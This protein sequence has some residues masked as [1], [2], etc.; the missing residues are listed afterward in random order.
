MNESN[1][2]A[3][4]KTTQRLWL[5]SSLAFRSHGLGDDDGKQQTKLLRARFQ[6]LES[7]SWHSALKQ[8]VFDKRQIESERAQSAV[9]GSMPMEL[10]TESRHEQFTQQAMK[11]KLAAAR[12]ILEGKQ[13]APPNCE[14][15]RHVADLVAASAPESEELDFA[16]ALQSAKAEASKACGP[17][18]SDV[19]R[20]MFKASVNAEP[21][22]SSMRNCFVQTLGGVQNGVHALQKWLALWAK[23][24]IAPYAQ[25]LWGRVMLIPIQD[26]LRPRP[27][28]L[29]AEASIPLP[30]V[31][32]TP[33]IRLIGLAESLLKI[34]EGALLDPLMADIRRHL[35]PNQLGVGT[36]DGVVLVIS[37]LRCWA[38]AICESEGTADDIEDPSAI[39]PIDLRNAYGMFLRSHALQAAIGFNSQVASLAAAEWAQKPEYYIEVQGKWQCQQTHRGFWQGRR[40]AML[41]FCLSLARSLADSELDL[42]A[43][44]VAYVSIQDDTYLIGSL[45]TFSN[46]RGQ[47]VQA[48]ARGGHELQPAKSKAWAPAWDGKPSAVLPDWAQQLFGIVERSE[49]GVFALGAASQGSYETLLGPWSMV[50]AKAR[51][52][53]NKAQEAASELRT[54]IREA[55][56]PHALHLAWDVVSQSN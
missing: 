35:E 50:A 23:D 26:G 42:R 52:R 49:G 40:L 32:A 5:L 54:Y 9:A 51:E 31:G 7:G 15:A 22:P 4:I 3:A 6:Q 14:T 33:K 18:V 45:K 43:S 16:R 27:H 41:M 19:R 39:V 47:L 53:L 8:Y 1:E 37:L 46:K 12:G 30:T 11:A 44:G 17:K 2:A 29:A 34:G 36:P 48:L 56:S 20:R 28:G 25:R 55:T 24:K 21:G 10:S 13:K 38:D